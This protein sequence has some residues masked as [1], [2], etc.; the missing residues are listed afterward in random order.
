[1]NGKD[2]ASLIKRYLDEVEYCYGLYHTETDT[3]LTERLQQIVRALM[4]IQLTCHRPDQTGDVYEKDLFEEV[5]AYI[6]F[7]AWILTCVDQT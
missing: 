4:Y 5:G 7:G 1:M 6:R 2:C 3:P